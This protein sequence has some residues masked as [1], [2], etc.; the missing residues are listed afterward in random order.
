[1]T[2]ALS[3]CP[4]RRTWRV[5]MQGGHPAQGVGGVKCLDLMREDRRWLL[6]FHAAKIHRHLF[7]TSHRQNL[8]MPSR[9][10]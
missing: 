9:T 5:R 7:D 2:L 1:M 4:G 3:L 8:S 6:L 10:R